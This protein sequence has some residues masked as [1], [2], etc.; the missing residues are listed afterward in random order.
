MNLLPCTSNSNNLMYGIIIF[1]MMKEKSI[2]HHLSSH[3]Q[4]I[5]KWLNVI[6][7]CR[8]R[9]STVGD[10]ERHGARGDGEKVYIKSFWRH[11]NDFLIV[12]NRDKDGQTTTGNTVLVRQDLSLSTCWKFHQQFNFHRSVLLTYCAWVRWGGKRTVPYKDA[13]QHLTT[14]RSMPTVFILF[15]EK[16]KNYLCIVP[17]SDLFGRG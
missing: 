13:Q 2:H 14:F 16:W 7:P 11:F 12:W 8:Y 4:K 17:T 3:F 1:I 9:Y 5:S 6:C 15:N 10:F